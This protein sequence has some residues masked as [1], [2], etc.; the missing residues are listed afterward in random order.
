MPAHPKRWDAIFYLFQQTFIHS[1]LDGPL[2][3]KKLMERGVSMTVLIPFLCLN[4]WLWSCV[5]SRKT[6]SGEISI[7][8]WN[9]IRRGNRMEVGFVHCEEKQQA[10]LQSLLGVLGSVV[11]DWEC[12][13]AWQRFPEQIPGRVV[14][15]D[16]TRPLQLVTSATKTIAK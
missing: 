4:S 10:S 15:A 9:D 12:V 7:H 8:G 1:S 3:R 11:W 13:F 6:L 2:E 14:R 16:S 5:E